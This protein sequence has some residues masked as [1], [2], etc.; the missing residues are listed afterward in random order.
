MNYKVDIPQNI[1]TQMYL[2]EEKTIEEIATSFQCSPTTIR[3]RLREYKLHSLERGPRQPKFIPKWSA[4]TAYSI[5][6][7]ATDRNLSKDG[8]HLTL[9]SSDLEILNNFKKCIQTDFHL[10]LH[11]K[12]NRNYYRIQW[13]NTGFY[14]WLLEIGLMPN[15]S[16]QLGPIKVPTE[17]LRDFVR[18]CLD[19][20]G[21]INTYIDNCEHYKDKTYSYQRLSIRFTSASQHFL[22]WLQISITQQTGARGGIY[23]HRS[24]PGQHPFGDLKYG[25]RDSIRILRWIYHSSDIPYLSRKYEKALPF[26]NGEG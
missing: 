26:L 11:V 14:N 8:R 5:G 6:L 18:G 21:N 1:L 24:R 22:E 16:N 13:S 17:Y 2:C 25:K 10:D 20:D 9:T 4:N 7:I 19:G 23:G 3:R 12:P 15:K